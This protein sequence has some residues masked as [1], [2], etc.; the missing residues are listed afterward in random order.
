MRYEIGD[1]ASPRGHAL[2]YFRVAGEP[3]RVWATYLVCPPI[4]LDLAKYLPPLFATQLGV[5]L[6]SA[7]SVYP[8]PPIPEAVESRGMVRAL[9][10]RRGDDLIDGGLVT[11]AELEAMMLAVS[12]A[13]QQY[14][15]S[16]TEAL[17]RAPADPLDQARDAP[18]ALAE[19]D[20]LLLEVMTPAEKVGRM[21][22]SLGTLRYAQEGGDEALA[23]ESLA[24]MERVALRLEP[25]Y[26]VPELMAAARRPGPSGRELCELYVERCYKLAAE[27]YAAVAD[28]ERRI[29]EAQ[30]NT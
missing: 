22:R 20:A 28:I 3:H 25:K 6:A 9:A 27:D 18:A 21:V 7:P 24:Q 16:Y 10:E 2:L 13:S 29:A 15:A 30:S 12:Q 17:S 8:L 11:S 23:V 1:P 4:S 26:R 19:V 14:A 5:N